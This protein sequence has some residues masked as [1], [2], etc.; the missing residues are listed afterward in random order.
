MAKFNRKMTNINVFR[1][2]KGIY[3]TARLEHKPKQAK[4]RKETKKETEAQKQNPQHIKG[5]PPINKHKPLEDKKI[6]KHYQFLPILE[7]KDCHQTARL[8][9]AK[10]TK[11]KKSKS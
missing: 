3:S 8:T 9:Q 4:T 7:T 2:M 6:V 1:G 5:H 10:Q 11:Y